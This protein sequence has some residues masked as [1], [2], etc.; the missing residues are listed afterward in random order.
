MAASE[1]G[2]VYDILG[3]CCGIRDFGVCLCLCQLAVRHCLF[4]LPINS[5]FH[6]INDLLCSDALLGGDRRKRFASGK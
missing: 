2:A 6:Q 5:R 4:D 1:S 3:H